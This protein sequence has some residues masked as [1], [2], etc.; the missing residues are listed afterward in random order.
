MRGD[1]DGDGR[2][3]RARRGVDHREGTAVDECDVGESAGGVE[4]DPVRVGGQR[5]GGDGV[6]RG[7][8]HADGVAVAVV[9]DVDLRTR[10]VHR[11]GDGSP[12]DRDGVRDGA[13]G[14][15]DHGD[16]PVAGVRD[17]DPGVVRSEGHRVGRL[18]DLDGG[19]HFRGGRVDHGDRA[20]VRV[21]DV[22]EAAGRVDGHTVGGGAHL[23][24][25]CGGVAAAVDRRDAAVTAVDDV[26]CGPTGSSGRGVG[27][28]QSG[29]GG[30]RQHQARQQAE[31]AT[32]SGPAGRTVP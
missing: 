23:D 16:G 31:S 7:T 10:R 17:V 21:R 28:G 2:R 32:G 26:E 6:G 18:P 8:D 4:G 22:R 20:V 24:A 13:G 29:H 25:G 30:G 9:G 5:Y 1:S 14:G 19:G 27:G 3:H 11:Q 15:A 12:A